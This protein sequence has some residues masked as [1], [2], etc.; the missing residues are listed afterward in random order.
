[1]AR[2]DG[3][4]IRRAIRIRS[5]PE[6]ILAAFFEPRD[7]AAWWDVSNAVT[8]PRPLAPYAVQ[9]PATTFRD[10]VLGRLGGTLHGSMMDFRQGEGFFLAEVFYTPPDTAPVGPMA[11]EV[12][13]RAID[14]GRST[15]LIVR[16]SGEDEGPRWRHYFAIMGGGW[17][18][19]LE[20]LREHLEWS[21]VKPHRGSTWERT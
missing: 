15:E 7:L 2:E 1:M 4:V 9:W 21:G 20:A 8:V 10:E 16:Q 13:V 5:A 11:L 12:Q 17:D 18:R 6:R 14:D 19:A 3:L